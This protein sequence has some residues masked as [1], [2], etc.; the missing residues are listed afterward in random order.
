[1]PSP[2]KVDIDRS[3]TT[4]EAVTAGSLSA[5]ILYTPGHTQGSICL[6][7]PAEKN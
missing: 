2:G 4:G 7:F 5:D 6:Y 1:M 3:I